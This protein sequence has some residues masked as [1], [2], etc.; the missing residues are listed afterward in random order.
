MA[1]SLPISG[2]N[3]RFPV[4][5]AFRDAAN[6]PVPV[7]G[8]DGTELSHYV[9][10]KQLQA[11][12]GLVVSGQIDG[13]AAPDPVANDG[14]LFLVTTAG[15]AFA[16]RELYIAR[17]GAWVAKAL[18]DGLL[19][20]IAD[21]L[22]GGAITFTGGRVHVYDA[23][24]DTWI[25]NGARTSLSGVTQTSFTTVAHDTASP[26][27][28]HTATAGH[29][30]AVHIRVVAAFDGAAATVDS[31]LDGAGDPVVD[32]ASL[33]A[34]DLTTLDEHRIPVS[35]DANTDMTLAVS[36]GAS[37]AGQVEII[38]EYRAG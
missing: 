7:A 24:S 5:F 9:T 27:Q 10:L 14:L 21:D 3:L 8:A 38:V 36:P 12:S 1:V 15:G 16:L 13:T 35:G 28:V 32:A 2:N 17:E 6:T 19:V 20:T 37:T 22:T 26:A 31:L 23:E 4:G 30:L 11:R 29:L 33:A 18:S 25:D 34:I